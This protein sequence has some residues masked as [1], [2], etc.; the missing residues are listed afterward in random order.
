[1][2]EEKKAADGASEGVSDST[3]LL[4]YPATHTVH[5]PSGPVDACEKHAKQLAAFGRHLGVHIAVTVAPDN[6]QCYNC[7]HEAGLPNRE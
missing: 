3:L 7:K 5:W 2:T 6:A 1:M 4:G